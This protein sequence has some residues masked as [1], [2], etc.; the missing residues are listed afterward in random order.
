MTDET[1][2]KE[3]KKYTN[4][5]TCEGKEYHLEGTDQYQIEST[6]FQL[7]VLSHFR[8]TDDGKYTLDGVAV[9]ISGT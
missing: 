2:N 3:P 1:K 5:L 6:G 7:Q 8:N 4:V 9:T